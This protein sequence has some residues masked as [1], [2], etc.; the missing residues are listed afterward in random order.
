MRRASGTK[1]EMS[2]MRTSQDITP[3]ENISAAI[4]GPMMYPTPRYSGVISQ[5]RTAL[6]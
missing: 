1:S 4:R 6:G 2:G 5:S 3:P